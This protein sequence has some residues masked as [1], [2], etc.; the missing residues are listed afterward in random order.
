MSVFRNIS[1]GFNFLVP[2]LLRHWMP[3]ETIVW[4]VKDHL[5][6]LP[7]QFLS[8]FSFSFMLWDQALLVLGDE[9]P[10]A[11]SCE[12][13]RGLRCGGACSCML[14]SAI[15][16]GNWLLSVVTCYRT[17]LYLKAFDCDCPLSIV[18]QSF[19]PP[20]HSERKAKM[21]KYV[22]IPFKSP[23]KN[24]SRRKHGT[25]LSSWFNW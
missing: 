18:G 13:E 6:C 1:L 24:I 15:T 3:N 7:H 4:R 25:E 9:L 21:S 2:N 17:S 8:A 11:V 22:Q 12:G 20:P 16:L 23:E 19:H 5:G 14:D 10:A